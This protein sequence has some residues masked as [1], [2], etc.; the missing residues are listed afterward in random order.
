MRI[1]RSL[2]SLLAAPS[3]TQSR[4]IPASI[5][6][7]KSGAAIL[8]IGLLACLWTAAL[9]FGG[10]LPL[11]WSAVEIAA[12]ALLGVALW[13]GDWQ[14]PALPIPWK[15]PALLL[16]F[17]ALQS[18]LVRSPFYLA[19]EKF[20]FLLVLACASCVAAALARDHVWR[21]RL[22]YGLVAL[23]LF[24]ALYGFLQSIAGWQRIFTYQKIF[25]TAQATGTYINPNHFAGLLEL[26]LPFSLASALE[27]LDHLD[28][29]PGDGAPPGLPRGE[30]LSALIFYS[31]I[32]LLLF[33]G[34]LLSRSRTGLL[35]VA[36]AAL[37]MVLVWVR[38]SARPGRFLPLLGLLTVAAL[39]SRW[40]GLGPLLARY[41]S[42]DIDF[43]TR[44]SV[45][46][47]SA[48]LIRSHPLLGTG[49]GT[50]ADSFTLVQTT[51]LGRTVDHAHNDYLEF[52]VEWGLPGAAIL[53]GLILWLLIRTI[54]VCL[55]PGDLACRYFALAYSGSILALL[56]HSLAD[57][58][59]QLP[60]NALLFSAI[61]GLAASLPSPRPESTAPLHSGGAA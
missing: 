50:F 30:R 4:G 15:A 41:S 58:N 57:F 31:F 27:R 10:T 46:K 14:K 2:A 56:V 17:V 11:V 39:F 36:I 23:G 33:S 9:S 26:I 22:M 42:L 48:A 29:L 16:L 47:D 59:L 13:S 54:R 6:D 3:S 20:L 51:L 53:F 7:P 61:L 28:S 45:W 1:R 8:T 40:I 52:A 44:L 34:I 21:S 35:S 18:A 24:E 5:S 32:T 55:Y 25:Y 19:R 60:A 43:S 12:L 49:L 38:R 37:A